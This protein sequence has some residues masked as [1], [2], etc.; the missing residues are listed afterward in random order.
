M[1]G[2]GL[3]VVVAHMNQRDYDVPLLFP[4]FTSSV[5]QETLM[6]ILIV[7]SEIS[8]YPGLAYMH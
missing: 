2:L 5:L 8:G 6:S 1:V 7:V 4:Y 3:R